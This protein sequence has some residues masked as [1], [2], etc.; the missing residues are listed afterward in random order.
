MSQCG[1]VGKADC[2]ITPHVVDISSNLTRVIILQKNVILRRVNQMQIFQMRACA[3]GGV[4][5]GVAAVEV[6]VVLPHLA[7]VT[8]KQQILMLRHVVVGVVG[9]DV[10]ARGAAADVVVAVTYES[11]CTISLAILMLIAAVVC[12]QPS[13]TRS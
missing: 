12:W 2:V 3:D 11:P 4:A 5:D 9:V 13:S 7:C 10:V 1:D 8:T 6:V